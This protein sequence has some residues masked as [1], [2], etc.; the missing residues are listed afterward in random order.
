MN[1]FVEQKQFRYYGYGAVT[2]MS[3]PAFGVKHVLYTLINLVGHGF[4]AYRCTAPRSRPRIVLAQMVLAMG[5]SALSYLYFYIQQ[6][7]LFTQ[8]RPD[9]GVELAVALIRSNNFR[10]LSMLSFYIWQSTTSLTCTGL[11]VEKARFTREITEV[12]KEST[13]LQQPHRK[14]TMECAPFILASS[15][16]LMILILHLLGYNTHK[17]IVSSSTCP[18]LGILVALV[19]L[20]ENEA[21][22]PNGGR[23][24]LEDNAELGLNKGVSANVDRNLGEESKVS[25]I[26]NRD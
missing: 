3:L 6:K 15:M 22:D 2:E 9:S 20:R 10:D 4:L 16:F 23:I 8:I 13:S 21:L 24:A 12:T 19:I 11:I 1:E 14:I 17:L 5:A 7:T 25:L 26:E 18:V